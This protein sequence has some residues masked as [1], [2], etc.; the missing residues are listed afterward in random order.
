MHVDAVP[1]IGGIVPETLVEAVVKYMKEMAVSQHGMVMTR[2]IRH[3]RCP[4]LESATE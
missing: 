4:P 2:N 1:G 3:Y